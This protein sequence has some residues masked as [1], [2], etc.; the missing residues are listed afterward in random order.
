MAFGHDYS[1]GSKKYPS[2]I[3]KLSALLAWPYYTCKRFLLG[4]DPNCLAKLGDIYVELGAYKLAVSCFEG[5]L[6][7]SGNAWIHMQLGHSYW[8][9]GNREKS[10][11]HWRKSYELWKAPILGAQLAKMEIEYGNMDMAKF[12]Y[13][14]VKDQV[15]KLDEHALEMLREVESKLKTANDNADPPK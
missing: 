2:I 12:L 15:E 7:Y 9:M 5:F 14:E 10:L 3:R 4:E 8:Q 11:E 6:V 13:L 1:F